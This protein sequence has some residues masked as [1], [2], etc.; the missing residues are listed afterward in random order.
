M[1]TNLV[2]ELNLFQKQNLIFGFIAIFYY[3]VPL[4][5][6]WLHQFMDSETDLQ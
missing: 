5:G 3:F 4:S 1:A 6:R 2:N